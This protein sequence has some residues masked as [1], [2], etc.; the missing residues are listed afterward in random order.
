MADGQG[1]GVRPEVM[2]ELVGEHAAELVARQ[3]LDGVRRDD[4]EVPAAGEGVEL[5]DGQH[6]DHEAPRRQA[7]GLQHRSPGDVEGRPFLSSRSAGA[8]QGRQDDDLH[9]SQEQQQHGGEVEERPSVT[10]EMCQTTRS[11]SHTT[12]SARS[13]SGMTASTGRNADT[14]ELSTRRRVLVNVVR[15]AF[16]SR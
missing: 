9:R 13:H 11:G 8:E 4:D 10:K 14:A 1:D 2:A 6:G 7:V 5:V 3:A 12:A 15:P 16:A